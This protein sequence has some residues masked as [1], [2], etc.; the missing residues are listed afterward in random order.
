MKHAMKD[1]FDL[2]LVMNV[3]SIALLLFVAA[4]PA[5]AGAGGGFDK[6]EETADEVVELL[7]TI[8]VVV[9]TAAIMWAGYKMIW[10][11]AK[12]ADVA[13]IL[14]GGT[15]IGGAAALAAWVVN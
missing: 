12:L 10:A 8:A 7:V 14:I 3:T 5:L 9:V 1:R 15:L 2:G 4:S 13:N 11:G 6:V